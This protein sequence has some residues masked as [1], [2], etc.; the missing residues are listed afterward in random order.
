MA[1]TSDDE[2]ADYVRSLG[3]PG[4]VDIHAHFMP[5]PVLRKVWAYFDKAG[6][7]LGRA[8]PIEY[9][10]DDGRR[11]RHLAHMDVVA[12]TSLNY[13][14]RPGMAAWLNQWSADFAAQHHDSLPRVISSATFFPEPGVT[15]YVHRAI[16]GGARVVKVHVQV[17]DFDVGDPRLD[18]VWGVLERHRIPVVIHAGSGPLP[19]T[20]TGPDPVS[21]LLARHPHLRLVVAHF[22]LPEAEAFLD[23]CDEYEGVGLDTTMVGTDF[24][25]AIGPLDRSLLPRVHRLGL[26]G[27]V[28]FGSDFPNIP[29]PYAHAIEALRRWDLGEDWMRSVLWHNAASLLGLPTAR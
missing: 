16:R 18:E 25:E 15:D 26:A 24:L 13:A 21:R 3:V 23:L 17:G 5:E 14:H 1:L 4:I 2:V 7:E 10:W 28:W 19:G 20:F 8:W 9:R 6:P 11:L 27:R 29:Y 12:T 22:G